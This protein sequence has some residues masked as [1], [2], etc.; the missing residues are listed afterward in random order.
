MSDAPTLCFL[1]CA[2]AE[3]PSG[4]DL[5]H[6]RIALADH[7]ATSEGRTP[8]QAF[9]IYITASELADAARHVLVGRQKAAEVIGAD[10]S[11]RISLRR[12]SRDELELEAGGQRLGCTSPLAL[13]RAVERGVAALLEESPLDAADPVHGDLWSALDELR[14]AIDAMPVA[15]AKRRRGRGSP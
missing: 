14:A 7:H 10:S 2:P 11:F 9:M 4:F 3:R 12:R 6:L 13:A 5:G 15:A 8:D 1:R